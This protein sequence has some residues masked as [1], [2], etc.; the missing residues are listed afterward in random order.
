MFYLGVLTP[1]VGSVVPALLASLIV[2]TSAAGAAV[3]GP[4]AAACESSTDRPAMLVRVD[5]LKSRAGLVRIQTYGGDPQNYFEP[6]AYLERVDVAPPASGPIEVCMPV[7]QPGVYAVVVKHDPGGGS[8][9]FALNNGGGFSG[10]PGFTAI[11]LVL[12]RKPAPPRVQIA[13][14]GV[15]HVP[16]TIHYLQGGS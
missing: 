4:H 15:T 3:L 14:R 16:V 5:G 7:P 12:R 2:T 11:D 9:G 10:N 8:F 13:V 6:G 1:K